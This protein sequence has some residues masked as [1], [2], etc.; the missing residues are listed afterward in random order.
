MSGTDYS[1]S[2]SDDP[3]LRRPPKTPLNP[4]DIKAVFGY[5]RDARERFHVGD[6][7]GAGSYGVVRR[8]TDK[9]TGKEYAIKTL[10]KKPKK[11][12]PTPRYLLKLRNE[13]DVMRQVGNSLN[14]VHLQGAYEDD[15]EIHLVM[16]LCTGG[17]LLDRL[18]ST[19]RRSEQD[20]AHVARSILQFIAQCHAKGVVYRD[21]KTDNFLFLNKSEASPL[22][23][24]DFGLSIRHWPN[25]PPMKSRTGTPAYMAPELILQNYTELAD[26]WSVGMLTYQLLTGHFPYWNDITKCSLKQLWH[27][28]VNQD[29]D[30]NRPDL[31]SSLSEGARDFLGLLLVRNPEKRPSAYEALKHPWVREGGTATAL[32]LQGSVVQRLQRFATYGDLKQLVLKRISELC[33][34]SSTISEQLHDLFIQLD[35]D[36]SGGLS[37]EELSKGLR[38][39]GYNLSDE[40]V[41]QLMAEVDVD[42]NGCVDFNEFM[43]T[44]IDW[45]EVQ[46]NPEEWAHYLDRIFREMDSDGNGFISLDE[47]AEYLPPSLPVCTEDGELGDDRMTIAKR[48]LREADRNEDGLIS[49]E[50]FTELMVKTMAPDCLEQYDS[51]VMKP[52]T[53][54]QNSMPRQGSM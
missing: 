5:A 48:M 14:V 16:E 38:A 20:I 18:L 4:E 24:T 12:P 41:T 27:A 26:V 23:A 31:V 9:D 40:E 49:R 3:I 11:G 39:Q 47:I 8:C 37:H 13:V 6:V 25:E 42:G 53:P 54:R 2:A 22:K 28:V 29:V 32:P 51:R 50:E 34:E 19:N 10:P 36:R 30:V 21:V 45:N 33:H 17:P 44:L 15:Y 43:A 52:A 1:P 7:I 35:A 46:M